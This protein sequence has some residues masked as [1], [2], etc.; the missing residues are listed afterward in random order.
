MKEPIVFAHRGASGYAPENTLE[1]FELALK[2]GARA[3]ESDV[4]ITRDR[5]LIF[6]HDFAIGKG[7]RSYPVSFVSLANLRKYQLKKTGAEVPLVEDVFANLQ[8]QDITW[9]ID[10]R[11]PD[12]GRKLY[13]LAKKYGFQDNLYM[14]DTAC[15]IKK[16]WERSG[17]NSSQFVWSVRDF[18][19]N[20]FGL[21]GILDHCKKAG[22]QTINFK[23]EWLTPEIHAAVT[24]LGIQIF[25]WDTHDE[26]NIKKALSYC[27]EAIY[28]NYPDVALKIVHDYA[29]SNNC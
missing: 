27:P 11:G 9:S 8:G 15:R 17:M 2:L 14:V 12:Q 5:Q 13:N 28:S 6:Y 1:A 7:I 4:K 18:Q 24:A 22:V 20:H 16:A 21:Q 26:E 10:A 3:L 25:I 29:A 23:L 19:I